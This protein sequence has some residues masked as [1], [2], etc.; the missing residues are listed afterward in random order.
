[1]TISSRKDSIVLKLSSAANTIAMIDDILYRRD[2]SL[3]KKVR[4]FITYAQIFIKLNFT[5]PDTNIKLSLD[6]AI[7]KNKPNYWLVLILRLHK[8][9][10]IAFMDITEIFSNLMIDM[11]VAYPNSKYIMDAYKSSTLSNIDFIKQ[12]T[13]GTKQMDTELD[14]VIKDENEKNLKAYREVKRYQQAV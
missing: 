3:E 6:D 2:L 13:N 14:T 12:F 8:R 10:S 7:R 11:M 5:L 1:M 9:K 4:K